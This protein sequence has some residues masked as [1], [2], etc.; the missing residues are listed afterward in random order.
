M[1]SLANERTDNREQ[2]N[3]KEVGMKPQETMKAGMMPQ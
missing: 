3:T 2:Y 1:S